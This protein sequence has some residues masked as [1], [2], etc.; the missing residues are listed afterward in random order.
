MLSV[1]SE[2]DSWLSLDSSNLTLRMQPTLQMVFRSSAGNRF[3]FRHSNQGPPNSLPSNHD[4]SLHVSRQYSDDQ[5]GLKI[6]VWKAEGPL[7]IKGA[8]ALGESG[9][10]KGKWSETM[11]HA[12]SKHLMECPACWANRL[13]QIE[14]NS[15]RLNRA[16]RNISSCSFSLLAIEIAREEE[17]TQLG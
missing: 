4:P 13:F 14:R 9:K 5:K 10:E 6:N 11:E 16:T 8:N 7:L 12:G 2:K 1:E 15:R 17:K 3:V